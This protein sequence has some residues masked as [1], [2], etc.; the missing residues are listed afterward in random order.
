MIPSGLTRVLDPTGPSGCAT[1]ARILA[2]D[3]GLVAVGQDRH[4]GC[5][6]LRL[7]QHPVLQADQKLG[8]VPCID[9]RRRDLVFVLEFHEHCPGLDH[10]GRIGGHAT[11][12]VDE[13]GAMSAHDPQK[14]AHHV[15]RGSG[16]GKTVFRR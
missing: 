5:K 8:V 14:S 12:G 6:E 16:V 10:L 9:V 4:P 11:V 3:G 15:A 13:I 1:S 2:Q 7:G